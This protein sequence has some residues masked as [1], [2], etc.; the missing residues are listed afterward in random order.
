MKVR[1]HN[2]TERNSRWSLIHSGGEEVKSSIAG[3]KFLI[4]NTRMENVLRR[5]NSR[6]WRIVDYRSSP[7]VYVK[8]RKTKKSRRP[9][10]FVYNYYIWKCH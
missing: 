5:M 9:D 4:E 8:T 6:L 1:G 7:I 3:E 10:E 2:E